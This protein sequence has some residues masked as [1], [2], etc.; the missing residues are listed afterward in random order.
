MM[1]IESPKVS[2]FFQGAKSLSGS[3]LGI[4]AMF[5]LLVYGVAALTFGLSV[6]QLQSEKI[7]IV[8][9]LVGFPVL[10]LFVFTYLVVAHHTKLYGPS[11]FVDQ[12]DFLALQRRYEKAEKENEILK[13]VTP[14]A[15]DFTPIVA[16]LPSTLP[17][18]NLL[19]ATTI[20][21]DDPQKGKW[22]GKRDNGTRRVRV[23]EIRKLKSDSDYYKIPLIVESTDP[24]NDPIRGK[25]T[26]YLHDSFDDDVRE[27]DPS[28]DGTAKLSLVAYGAF[29]VGIKCDDGSQLEI[30]LSDPDIDAPARF[31]LS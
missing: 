20:H 10:V 6:G 21:S 14:V 13:E 16:S 1:K 12:K 28:A 11:D 31:K 30:D 9:F 5:I 2:D 22:G 26:F 29:T 15:I 27:R 17:S 18:G 25:T 8:W 23:G 3:P 4:I 19:P 24:V 7:I